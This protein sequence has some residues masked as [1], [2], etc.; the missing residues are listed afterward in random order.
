MVPD[1]K[2][3]LTTEP[4]TQL[5]LLLLFQLHFNR[6]VSRVCSS[7]KEVLQSDAFASDDQT[8][9]PYSTDKHV[10][11]DKSRKYNARKIMD[12]EPSTI[13]LR[14]NHSV[15]TMNNEEA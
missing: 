8:Q 6:V 15:I 13:Q 4:S 2:T 11:G 1:C 10:A 7:T 5:N 14:Q 9:K 3:P 12:D